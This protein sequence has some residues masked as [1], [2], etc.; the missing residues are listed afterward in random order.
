MCAYYGGLIRGLLVFVWKDARAEWNV[1]SGMVDYW[2]LVTWQLFFA[3]RLLLC[4]CIRHDLNWRIYSQ[5]IHGMMQREL[6]SVLSVLQAVRQCGPSSFYRAQTVCR[7]AL[8]KW[9]HIIKAS[10][11]SF[12]KFEVYKVTLF[13]GK[14]WC[15]HR[16]SVRRYYIWWKGQVRRKIDIM[17]QDRNHNTTYIFGRL[18]VPLK[19][20]LINCYYYLSII[21]YAMKEIK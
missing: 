2:I 10:M 3:I 4:E 17:T 6:E 8:Q 15:S 13:N 21:A 18:G 20:E 16:T 12:Y 14:P 1:I 7:V 9:L 11:N 5:E 19:Y